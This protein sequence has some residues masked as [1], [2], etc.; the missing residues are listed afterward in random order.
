MYRAAPIDD[1]AHV[2]GQVVTQGFRL[3]Q[4]T[5]A[6]AAQ[7]TDLRRLQRHFG[8]GFGQSLRGSLK[9]WAMGRHAHCQTLGQAGPATFR[10]LG[11]RFHRRVAT[12]NH[13][14]VIGVDIGQI[15]RHFFAVHLGQQSFHRGQVQT[16]DRGHAVALWISLLH[17]LT[18]QADQM[19][20]I[21][22]TQGTGHHRCRVSAD[23]Q[24]GHVVGGHA[25]LA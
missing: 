23:R 3:D 22:E 2:E 18:A 13:H 6:T 11:H 9:Q 24:A 14:L 4:R 21:A 10:Q 12:G 7:V 19:Q 25:Q 5:R 16:D 20:R 8:E 17:Q 15:N 1:A